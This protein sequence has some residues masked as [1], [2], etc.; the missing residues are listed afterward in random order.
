VAS[1]VN[2][3]LASRAALPAAVISSLPRLAGWLSTP[4]LPLGGAM[5]TPFSIPSR[6]DG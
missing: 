2:L 6:S 4:F 5:V 3:A 1:F